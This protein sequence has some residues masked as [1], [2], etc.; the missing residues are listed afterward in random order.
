MFV[1]YRFTSH[2][3]DI[4]RAS[5]DSE[6]GVITVICFA[7][8]II[9]EQLLTRGFAIIL[10]SAYNFIERRRHFDV[11]GRRAY[12]ARLLSP[13]DPE[14]NRPLMLGA[15]ARHRRRPAASR[16]DEVMNTSLPL[17]ALFVRRD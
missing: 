3:Q 9:V 4:P 15:P 6:A 1:T 7:M 8:S 10:H 13:G 16:R 2:L 17:H 5:N 14:Y 11:S 12:F